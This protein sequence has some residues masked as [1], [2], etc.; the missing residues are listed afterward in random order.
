M[1]SRIESLPLKS[2]H[3]VVSS[4]SVFGCSCFGENVKARQPVVHEA[5]SSSLIFLTQM[6]ACL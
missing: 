4:Y 6:R 5:E 3:C 2:I 1:G